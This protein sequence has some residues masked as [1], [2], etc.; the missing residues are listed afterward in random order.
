[1]AAGRNPAAFF[2]MSRNAIGNIRNEFLVPELD[3]QPLKPFACETTF[4]EC[5]T[6]AAPANNANIKEM[7]GTLR[8]SQSFSRLAT[9]AARLSGRPSAFALAL[10]VVVAWA[11]TGPMFDFSDTWQLVINTGTTVVTFLMVFLI[12]NSQNRDSAAIQVKLDEIIQSSRAENRFIGIEHLTEEEIEEL[13]RKCE[14]RAKAKRP[15]PKQTRE[16]IAAKAD[17]Q[18]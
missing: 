11:V 14:Q 16:S 12:Q 6:M 15:R 10:A 1:M 5:P 2:G 3:F 18:A 4:P 7:E 9:L 13:R 17:S 8:L